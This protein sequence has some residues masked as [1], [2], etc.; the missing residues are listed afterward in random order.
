MNEYWVFGGYERKVRTI[1]HLGE[2]SRAILGLQIA[3]M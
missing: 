1:N 3:G 2:L